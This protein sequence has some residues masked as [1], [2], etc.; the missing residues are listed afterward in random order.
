MIGVSPG[1]VHVQAVRMRDNEPRLESFY[2]G[3]KKRGD[4]VIVQKYDSFAGC[5]PDRTVAELSPLDRLPCRHLARD[6]AVLIDGRVPNCKHCLVRGADSR[7]EYAGSA[8]NAFD[9]G[10]ET[11]WNRMGAW[12]ERHLA[13]DYPEPCGRCDEYHTFNA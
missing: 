7:L 5:L 6:I 10:L 4:K 13:S 11:T 9:D 8:G 1:N 12:Y 2:R 3:W